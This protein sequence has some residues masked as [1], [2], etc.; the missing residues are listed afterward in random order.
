MLK[1]CSAIRMLPDQVADEM[2][3]AAATMWYAARLSIPMI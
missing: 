3:E 1:S 2:R